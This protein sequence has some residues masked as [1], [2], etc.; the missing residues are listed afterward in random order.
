MIKFKPAQTVRF[1]Y[2]HPTERIDEDTG[3]RFKEVFVLNPNYGGKMHGLDLKRMTEAEREV[4]KGVFN[5]KKAHHKLPLVNDVLARMDPL[6]EIKN[7]HSFYHKFVKIFIRNKDVYRIYELPRMLSVTIVRE[8]KVIGNVKNP[9][10]LFHKVESKTPPPAPKPMDA[11]RLALI[12]KIAAEKGLAVSKNVGVPVPPRPFV[13]GGPK[14][15]K[16]K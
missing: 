4:I 6:K 14:A 2:N 1:T 11:A 9:N 12:N 15:P 7:P 16:K 10:P 3:D 8:T 5:P 13:P